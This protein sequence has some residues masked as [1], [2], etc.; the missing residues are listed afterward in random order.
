MFTCKGITT[1]RS[2]RTFCATDIPSIIPIPPI[3][4][5]AHLSLLLLSSAG[6]LVGDPQPMDGDR[7]PASDL[8]FGV[9]LVVPSTAY[10]LT[11]ASI[12]SAL[13]GRPSTEP[14]GQL[15][16]LDKLVG[17]VEPLEQGE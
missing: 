5:T 11:V 12:L 1:L 13:A 4:S 8:N 10:P 7:N 2:Y 15:L 6:L 3:F 9:T 17:V 16:F 14:S